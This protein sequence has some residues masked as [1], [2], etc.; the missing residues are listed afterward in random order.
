M[1]TTCTASEIRSNRSFTTAIVESRAV[2][3]MAQLFSTVLEKDVTNAGALHILNA[4]TS[5]SAL[6][7]LGWISVA[8]AALMTAWFAISVYQ[9]SRD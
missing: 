1:A 6:L 7:L 5:F 4:M 3:L 9:C 2:S 8:V